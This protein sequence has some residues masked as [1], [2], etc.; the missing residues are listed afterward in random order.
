MKTKYDFKQLYINGDLRMLGSKNLYRLWNNLMFK[1]A[2][3]F[4]LEKKKIEHDKSRH[5]RSH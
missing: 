1:L 5:S 3:K 2:K 4:T